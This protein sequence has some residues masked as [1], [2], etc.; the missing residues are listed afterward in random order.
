VNDPDRMSADE[1]RAE[2]ERGE[3]EQIVERRSFF[4]GYTWTSAE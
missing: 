4:A 1:L 3:V 2:V